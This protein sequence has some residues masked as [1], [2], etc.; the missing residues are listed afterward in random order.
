M[1][2]TML[3]GM[4][5]LPGAVVGGIIIGQ[6]LSWGFY[7]MGSLIQII[8]FVGIVIMVYFRP[9]GLMGQEVDLGV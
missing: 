2:S 1:L 9:G 5:S 4:S 7:F 3:G 6:A 8:I